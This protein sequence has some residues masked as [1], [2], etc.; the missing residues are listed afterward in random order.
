MSDTVVNIC[1]YVCICVYVHTHTHTCFVHTYTYVHVGCKCCMQNSK[2][3][4]YVFYFGACVCTRVYMYVCLYAD[5]YI[6]EYLYTYLCVF[7]HVCTYVHILS[8]VYTTHVWPST[9]CCGI[10]HPW[11]CHCSMYSRT[12]Q[13][14]E[15]QGISAYAHMY[16]THLIMQSQKGT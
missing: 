10:S 4:V 14:Q 2:N 13:I 8:S 6:C 3:H 16:A 12:R 9:I 5:F 15:C 1:M 7:M 11:L